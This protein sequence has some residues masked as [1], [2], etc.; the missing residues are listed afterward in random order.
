MAT[1]GVR[2]SETAI[3][4]IAE[5]QKLGCALIFLIFSIEDGKIEVEH[6]SDNVDFGAFVSLLPSDDHRFAIYRMDYKDKDGKELQKICTIG[7]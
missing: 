4:K 3:S 5:F 1:T 6:E 7:W 2:T